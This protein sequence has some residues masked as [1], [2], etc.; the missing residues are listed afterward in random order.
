MRW[1]MEISYHIT[2]PLHRYNITK[3]MK[4]GTSNG[5]VSPSSLHPSLRKKKNLWGCLRSGRIFNAISST[6]PRQSQ[7]S[8][9]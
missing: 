8:A 5:G 2:S 3:K 7:N 6:L 1:A 4:D 9:R